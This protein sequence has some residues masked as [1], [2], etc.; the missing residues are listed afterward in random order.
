VRHVAWLI[1]LAL[2]TPAAR[3]RD[4]GCI[5]PDLASQHVNKDVCLMAH[6]YDVIELSDG[7]RFLDLCSPLTTDSECRFTVVSFHADRKDVGDLEQYR[8]LDIQLRGTIR[9]F[10]T[11]MEMVLSRE[12][13]FHGG[14][15]KFRPNPTLL[16]GFSAENHNTAFTDHAVNS[17]H[18]SSFSQ[19]H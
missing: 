1:A 5:T 19:R 14:S 3:A 6:V 8:G 13:Q 11:R 18:S 2:I 9:P 17:R 12:R 16:K 15:E 7:T 4:N 10:N